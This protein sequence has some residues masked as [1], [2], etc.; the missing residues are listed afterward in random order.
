MNI[1]VVQSQLCPGIDFPGRTL[2]DGNSSFSYIWT[3]N[4]AKAFQT[5]WENPDS[6]FSQFWKTVAREL[7]GLPGVIGGELWN[8]PFLVRRLYL[9]P[10]CL[11][12]WLRNV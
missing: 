2:C 8:E 4:G 6:G 1:G 10:S 11:I 7:H 12:N 3:H 9:K 5:L